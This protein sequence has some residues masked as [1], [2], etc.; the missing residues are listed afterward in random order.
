MPRLFTRK[1][2]TVSAAVRCHI[3]LVRQNNE[4]NFYFSGV[5]LPLD[6]TDAGDSREGVFPLEQDPV[7]AVCDG[8]GGEDDGETAAYMAVK[9][10][11]GEAAK[12]DQ[13]WE[14]A[15]KAISCEISLGSSPGYTRGCT[16][17]LLA[18]KN[19]RAGIY[20]VG[21]SRI[22]LFRHGR[23][24]QVSRDHSPVYELYEAGAITREEVRLHPRNNIISRF[25]GMEEADAYEPFAHCVRIFCRPEDIFLICSDGLTDLVPEFILSE[26]LSAG[27]TVRV[28]AQRLLDEALQRG[29]RDNVTL[30]V[31]ALKDG[32]A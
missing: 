22:Y 27:G 12:Q 26:I 5:Y 9:G 8:M 18:F 23:L 7:F 21:D 17:A 3:G 25:L 28:I 30:I 2:L 11:A 6:K 14:N 24:K 13:D 31:L 4:D 15:L 29:G 1:K 20:N 19:S 10:I 16:A 32:R